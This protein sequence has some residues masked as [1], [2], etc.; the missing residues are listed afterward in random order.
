MA[1]YIWLILAGIFLIFEIFTIGFLVFWL[2]IS[3][4]ITMLVSFFT[5]NIII[6]TSVFVITSTILIL[7]TR[8]LIKK[9]GLKNT[10]PTNYKSIIGKKGMV[11]EDI[12]NIQGTGLVKIN[13]E[14]WSALSNNED[15][16]IKKDAEVEIIRIKGVKVIVIPIK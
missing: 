4:L 8:P 11:I 9:F 13:G 3:A 12:D 1:W 15:V 10:V 7:S 5:H 6:Q 16:L 14:T 2:A